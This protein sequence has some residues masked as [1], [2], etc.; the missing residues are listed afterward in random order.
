MTSHGLGDWL[1][2]L[3]GRWDAL[4]SSEDLTKRRGSCNCSVLHMSLSIK[5]PSASIIM[6]HNDFF[7]KRGSAFNISGWACV[8]KTPLRSKLNRFWHLNSASTWLQRLS[9]AILTWNMR[10]IKKGTLTLVFS[11]TVPMSLG[12][13]ESALKTFKSTTKLKLITSSSE[14]GVFYNF[15]FVILCIS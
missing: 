9:N 14:I 2:C 15:M 8:L 3:E 13:K 11:L 7:S 12:R 4:Q 1:L 10:Q 6:L 5:L